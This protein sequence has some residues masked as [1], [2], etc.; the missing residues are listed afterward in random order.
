MARTNTCEIRSSSARLRVRSWSATEMPMSDG[1][2]PTPN[3][4]ERDRSADRA[5]ARHGRGD[6]R[7]QEPAR[8]ES[9]KQSR[10]ERMA[11]GLAS[12][13]RR[14]P[15]EDAPAGAEVGQEARQR[16]DAPGDERAAGDDGR[17]AL[18]AQ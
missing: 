9:E 15:P 6:R 13:G 18:E 7:V 2:V 14:E 3:S 4:T 5:A 10:D 17:G 11:R 8:Q 1:T 16:Q 12:Q